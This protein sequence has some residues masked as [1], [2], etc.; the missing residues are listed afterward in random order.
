MSQASNV[1]RVALVTGGTGGVGQVLVN[2]LKER[3]CHVAIADLKAPVAGTFELAPADS[4]GDKPALTFHSVDVSDEES[5]KAA[6][7][8]VL[9]RHG[10]LDILVNNAGVMIRR[11]L[12]ESSIDDWNSIMDVNVTGALRMSKAAH[13]ALVT[14]DAASIINITSTHGLRPAHDVA[15]YAVSKAAL[16]QL[17]KVMALEWAHSGIRVN[18]VAPSIIATPMTAD[19]LVHPHEF[20]SRVGLLPLGQA[21]SAEDVASAV[22][23]LALHAAMVTGETI[24]VDGGELINR[25]QL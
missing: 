1:K 8:E 20:H 22:E 25:P 7:D 3:G 5:C 15:A 17:T 4:K 23:Y 19:L 24:A 11:S 21:V 10:Q 16:T 18:A 14:S 12:L 9:A 2:R 6:V 13:T